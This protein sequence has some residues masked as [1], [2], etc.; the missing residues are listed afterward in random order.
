MAL[1]QP[2]T[3]IGSSRKTKKLILQE[4]LRQK[5]LKTGGAFDKDI[6]FHKDNGGDCSALSGTSWKKKNR[7]R[8]KLKVEK[9]MLDP[10][11]PPPPSIDEE[12]EDEISS[13][14]TEEEQEVYKNERGKDKRRLLC[15]FVYRVCSHVDLHCML[16][17]VRC[18]TTL[19]YNKLVQHFQVN[20]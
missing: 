4:A 8:R 10:K 9:M 19:I 17:V 6:R 14:T 16:Y 2:S 20:L 1:L 3:S 11:P 13:T 7:K 15:S 12:S 18:S 5:Q